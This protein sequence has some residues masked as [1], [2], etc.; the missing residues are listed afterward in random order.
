MSPHAIVIAQDE[1]AAGAAPLNRFDVGID[2]ARTQGE[3]IQL[4]AKQRMEM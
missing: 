1:Q 3:Q 4:H 2:V